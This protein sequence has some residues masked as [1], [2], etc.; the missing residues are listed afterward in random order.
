MIRAIRA[1]TASAVALC[2]CAGPPIPPMDASGW[3]EIRTAKFVVVGRI[4][5]DELRDLV[6]ELE[7]FDSL[8]ERV[9]TSPPNPSAVPVQVYVFRTSAEADRFTGS[10]AG[11]LIPTLSGYF[12]M[13]SAHGPRF[14]TRRTLF[15]EYVH[16]ILRKMILDH[17]F[18]SLGMGA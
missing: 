18:D 4:S 6:R 15:H 11:V 12:A 9:T 5:S 10:A 16:F 14:E 7:L 8:I 3:L 13:L 2:A 1:V 17:L